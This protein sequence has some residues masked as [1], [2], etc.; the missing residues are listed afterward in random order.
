MPNLYQVAFLTSLLFTFSTLVLLTHFLNAKLVAAG[1][2]FSN[3]IL[4]GL[5][6][7]PSPTMDVYVPL[8]GTVNMVAIMSSPAFLFTA[9]IVVATAIY[10]NFIHTG[11]YSLFSLPHFIHYLFFIG[12]TKPLNPDAWQQ[13]PLEKKIV[14]SP[15]TAM[16]DPSLP[17]LFIYSS[18]LGTGSNSHTY[19]MFLAFP[20]DS[21]YLS[22][23]RLTVKWL[24]AAT[25]PSATMM[26]ADTLI[27]S[28]KYF[29]SFLFYLPLYHPFRPTKTATSQST[30][31]NSRSATL[32]A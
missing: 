30:F 27:S 13:Y 22:L 18:F 25:L 11:S 16:F 6:D 8:L 31:L 29:I 1:Y 32:F 2:H 23:P 17:L 4:I 9:V 10:S 15:N 21:T 3:L 20:L 12:R 28:S 7:H 24:P 14:V 26:T 19:R 5:P